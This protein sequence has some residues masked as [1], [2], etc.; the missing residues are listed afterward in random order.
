MQVLEVSEKVWKTIIIVKSIR[1]PHCTQS[2][3]LFI[4]YA[5]YWSDY[6]KIKI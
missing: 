4:E 5:I 1:V 3:K 2:L 6:S